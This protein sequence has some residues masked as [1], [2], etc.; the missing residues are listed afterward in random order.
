[1]K[2]KHV[3]VTDRHIQCQECLRFLTSLKSVHVEMANI[4]Y[5]LCIRCA[6]IQVSRME[7]LLQEAAHED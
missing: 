2:I 7:T 5:D 3:A 4:F 6:E 1:M